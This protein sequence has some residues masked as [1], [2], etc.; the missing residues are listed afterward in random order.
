MAARHRLGQDPNEWLQAFS[1]AVTE[2]GRAAISK[3]LLD[4]P[5]EISHELRGRDPRNATVRRELAYAC[6]ADE[7][8][9]IRLKF[10]REERFI[11]ISRDQ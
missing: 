2:S 10:P 3:L 5:H 1:G 8:G 6:Q 11:C 7:L 9:D 4:L